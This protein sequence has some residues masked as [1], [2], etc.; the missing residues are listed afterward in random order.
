MWRCMLQYPIWVK[1]RKNYELINVDDIQLVS[2]LQNTQD[3]E[4]RN[5][6]SS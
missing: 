2:G 4:K 3:E 5:F 1:D 6:S